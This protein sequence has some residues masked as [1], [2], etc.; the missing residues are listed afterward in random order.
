MLCI[1][2]GGVYAP[3]TTCMATPLLHCLI[4]HVYYH[5]R[6]GYKE[7]K[8]CV[9]WR[10]G[11]NDG[12]ISSSHARVVGNS[13]GRKPHIVAQ[14]LQCVGCDVIMT[15]SASSRRPVGRVGLCSA[16]SRPLLLTVCCL[17]LVEHCK[18]YRM[19]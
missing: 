3:N 6:F 10:H 11:A 7:K 18:E 15:S 9:H 13:C 14:V 16:S 19:S 2:T 1:M 17:P 8:L 12:K 4:L 5:T